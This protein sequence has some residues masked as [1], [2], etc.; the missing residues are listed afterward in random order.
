M[1]NVMADVVVVHG[2]GLVILAALLAIALRVARRDAEVCDRLLRG[3]AVF[4]VV[5]LPLILVARLGWLP[6]DVGSPVELERGVS[7]SLAPIADPTPEEATA[8][9]PAG[10]PTAATSTPID[11]LPWL[12]AAWLLGVLAT[13]AC[14]LVAHWRWRRL[15]ALGRPLDADFQQTWRQVAGAGSNRVRVL[16][17]PG[18]RTPA[19]FGF[20]RPVVLVPADVAPGALT[21]AL[22]H[23]LAHLER[24]DPRAVLWHAL[25]RT[26]CWHHPVAWWLAARG[27][28]ARE[29]ACD[30][31]VVRN[32]GDAH[33]YATALLTFAA[34]PPAVLPLPCSADRLKERIEMMTHVN[35]LGRPRR[36]ATWVLAV[37][38]VSGLAVAQVAAG[39]RRA[40]QEKPKDDDGHL[41]ISIVRSDHPGL[42]KDAPPILIQ[43]KQPKSMKELRA[44]L[45]KL[46][47]PKKYPAKKDPTGRPFP[48]FKLDGDDVHVSSRKLVIHS[49]GLQVFG[50]VQALMQTCTMTPGEPFERALRLSPL[51]WNIELRMLDTKLKIATP[52]P[53]DRG[54]GSDTIEVEEEERGVPSFLRKGGGKDPTPRPFSEIILKVSKKAWDV[55][56]ADREVIILRN[57]TNTPFGRITK[58]LVRDGRAEVLCDPPAVISDTRAWLREAGTAEKRPALKINAYPR[59]PFA[60][61]ATLI[62]AGMREGYT[63]ITFSG[64]PTYLIRELEAGRLR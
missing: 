31:S 6:L 9:G 62:E 28:Q 7:V 17:C 16:A 20:L 43:G 52:L 25:L 11:P 19:C 59:T 22:R 60:V 30:A 1:M 27:A 44:W 33:R 58:T 32:T 63:S 61:V 18:L 41:H 53:V 3:A 5:L 2:A 26:L 35:G 57:G 40:P 13:G 38:T 29:T 64:I 12:V 47:D 34:R 49:D 10:R 39:A 23:E 15:V 46:A 56:T 4:S 42:R 21:W 45:R 50:W 37:L 8:T 55:P 24:R 51:I 36:I 48:T 14:H 54:V